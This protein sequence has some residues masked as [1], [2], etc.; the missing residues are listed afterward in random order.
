MHGFKSFAK[1]T[2][3]VFGDH[4]NSVLGPNGS[5]KS[6]VLDAICFVLGRLSSKS[7][8]AEKS[9]NLIYNGG[10][11]KSPS[12]KAE[13][14]IYFDNSNKTFPSNE[15]EIKISRIVKKT[16][17]SVYK[18]NDK[19]ST[20][21]QILD[22]MSVAKIDPDGY[23]IILQGDI[24]RFVE[25][26][27]VE[28]R[29][30]LEEISGIS[31][32][33]DK[34]NKAMNEL[35]KV[36][37][38]LKE[39][40][41]ILTERETYLKEL[42][43]E[44]NQAAKYK[45]MK[46]KI[47][48]SKA[49]VLH[50]Q[51]EE[52]KEDKEKFENRKEK[53]EVKLEK[54]GKEIVDVKD[55]IQGARNG[56][57][58]LT[59]E[60]E[61]KGEKEQVQIMKNLEGLRVEIATNKTKIENLQ[62]ELGKIVVRR[63]QLKTDSKDISSK[64]SGIENR[65]QELEKKKVQIDREL[66]DILKTIDN[67]KQKRN[68]GEIPQIEAEV[69]EIDNNVDELQKSVQELRETQ[70][71]LLREKDRVE[72]KISTLDDRIDKVKEVEI[73]HKKELDVLKDKK[74]SFKKITVELNKNLADDSSFAAQI[75]K[76]RQDLVDVEQELSRLK[77]RSVGIRERMSANIAVKKI[78]EQKKSIKGIYG[79]VGELGT[80][81]T[82]YSMALEIAAGS[83]VN[84]VVVKDDK[85][86]AKCIGYL[87]KN[88][89]G[90][91]TFLPINKIRKMSTNPDVK[92]LAK[93]RGCSGIAVDLVDFDSKFKVIFNYLFSN[94]LVVDDINVARR[95]GIGSA[96]MVTLEG[97]LAERSG[98]MTGGFRKRKSGLGFQE[99]ETSK[100]INE[101][102]SQVLELQNV[103][104]VLSKRRLENEQDII[105]LR[106]EK[107]SL[108]GEIIKIEKSLH[109][110]KGDVGVN[111][112]EKTLLREELKQ[113]TRTI[114]QKNKDIQ[115]FNGEFAKLKAS[116]QVLRSK[117]GDLQNP[118]LLAELNTFEDK[119]N[120]LKEELL[121]TEHEIKSAHMQLKEL[122]GPELEKI[123]KI[124]KQLDKE[125][126]SFEKDLKKTKEFVKKQEEE[127]KHKEKK[128]KAFYS[129]FKEL[130]NER[131]KLNKKQ[132]DL[133]VKKARLED[134]SRDIEMRI[135]NIALK[136]AA[137]TAELSGLEKE[138]EQF[139]GVPILRQRNISAIKAEITRFENLVLAMGNV[140][141][142]ALEIYDSV[143]KEYEH[144]LKKKDLLEKEKED[145]M[146]LMDE[147]EGRKAELF[148]KTFDSVNEHFMQIFN[149]LTA[150]GRAHLALDNPKDPFDGGVRIRVKI[151][152]RRFMD[153]RS[154]SGGEKT[155]TAL[156]LIFSVQEHDPA[157]FYVLDEVDAALD[158]HNSEK[159]A[160]LV[161][162]YSDHAQYI[163]VTHNDAII[164]EADNLYGVSMDEH[165]ISK[166]V[167]LKI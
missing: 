149:Q 1:R 131:D 70:Q 29:Q 87:K 118:E 146:K 121:Q 46:D 163:I 41:I 101:L 60:I 52:K 64:N 20:R 116:K 112:K 148:M 137:V 39:A 5:G 50:N 132:R 154:L 23:N 72:Y 69:S 155:L 38:S 157:S 99:K 165:S 136:N 96:R 55:K 126:V 22:L 105:D 119:K 31:I 36:E 120:D 160:K 91:A 114:E 130:F 113:L 8:R 135:N 63:E 76:K 44:R 66:N 34:K 51:I 159:L 109:L 45:D 4:F 125:E 53:D 150:K 90:R 28:R 49:T 164:S 79:T 25:M 147:I 48:S 30:V 104:R 2:E 3:L 88:K 106:K 9:A 95:I 35:D 77:T 128:Q 108:E 141:L 74:S 7:L 68:L 81:G 61:K 107:A 71:N 94:T 37:D 98:A 89:L 43:K 103:V 158:K 21:Q 73:E 84:N 47:D 59:S 102:E 15:S 133:E 32:Y 167:S 143:H 93:S 62:Q 83:K 33:Q 124:I 153:I 127:L 78:M 161:R 129:K 100:G 11:K 26:S 12:K 85:V 10:K 18:I 65:T 67:F 142:K 82:K 42:R 145:V 123:Q 58:D 92:R 56:V 6:N 110:E 14:S 16:G 115:K 86:A 139:H 40:E 162:K 19:T 151:T 57:Y 24:V 138:Y 111:K 122:L 80:V 140:N 27:S 97:D 156:A 75:G 144:L 152:G 134:Q 17:Q 117:I 166:V 13:V 54:I